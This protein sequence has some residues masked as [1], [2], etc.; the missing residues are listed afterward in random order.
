MP[1]TTLG[2]GLA[3]NR[4]RVCPPPPRVQ[5]T[6]TAGLACTSNAHTSCSI[7]AR[8]SMVGTAPIGTPSETQF[9]HA[10][11]GIKTRSL[12][13]F[14]TFPTTRGPQLK[15]LDHTNHERFRV[16]LRILAELG[17][18]EHPPLA[19]QGT[20]VGTGAKVPD[21]RAGTAIVW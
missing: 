18:N 1:N 12:T 17:R 3:R 4:A 5:S 8:C 6:Y 11:V 2:G 16:N 20:D 10:F 21:E 19:V 14:I 15:L 7:T 13:G 9:H